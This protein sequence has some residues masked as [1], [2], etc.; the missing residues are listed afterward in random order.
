[1]AKKKKSHKRKLNK[2]ELQKMQKQ[3][4]FLEQMER[5]IKKMEFELKHQNIVNAKRK[6]IRNLKISVRAL[7]LVAPYV[8][9][10][11]VT[12]GGF[13]QLNITPFYNGD[14]WEVP[15]QIMTEFDTLGNERYEKKYSSFGKSN[16]LYYYTKWKQNSDGTYSRMI[17]TYPIKEKTYEEMVE[18][19]Q[20]ENVNLEEILGES[21]EEPIEEIKKT[22]TEEELQEEAFI[23]A[24]VYSEDEDDYIICREDISLNIAE[25]ILYVVITAIGEYIA[26]KTRKKFSS[27]NFS[28][29]VDHIREQNPLTDNESVAKKLELKRENYNRMIR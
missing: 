10:A 7:Q 12:F 6:T 21:E 9:I 23:K 27:F 5:D 20:Q 16:T 8:L 22:L 18:L 29:C 26:I 15:A 19:L 17:E 25:T 14:E 1:M 2:Q 24:V 11:G 13:A 28:E 4:K 3:Q